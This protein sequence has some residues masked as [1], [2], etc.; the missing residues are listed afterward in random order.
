M[1]HCTE[2]EEAWKQIEPDWDGVLFIQ[3]IGRMS[4]LEDADAMAAL[5]FLRKGLVCSIAACLYSHPIFA[6]IAGAHSL[7][8][9]VREEVLSNLQAKRIQKWNKLTVKLKAA[10][11]I[12]PSCSPFGP[13][14]T[15]NLMD[16]CCIRYQYIHQDVVLQLRRSQISSSVCTERSTTKR[17]LKCASLR[18]EN[19]KGDP[20]SR[21]CLRSLMMMI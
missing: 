20:S 21:S 14:W 5:S 7:L 11:A 4:S 16:D 19:V 10:L 3:Q 8:H 6:S 12:F 15:R 13:I 17:R 1:K 9:G 18:N 2:K